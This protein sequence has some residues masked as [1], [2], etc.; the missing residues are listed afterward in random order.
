MMKNL[1]MKILSFVWKTRLCYFSKNH[2]CG[3]VGWPIIFCDFGRFVVVILRK[4]KLFDSAGDETPTFKEIRAPSWRYSVTKWLSPK[5]PN[6]ANRVS[7]NFPWPDS[8]S[9]GAKSS[10]YS[11]HTFWA[12]QNP[13]N[14]IW[15]FF[16]LGGWGWPG[17]GEGAKSG[18][19]SSVLP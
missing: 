7:D 1:K 16:L 14:S 2:L 17:K 3:W 10:V 5:S 19:A 8:A 12:Y 6:R 4:N 11:S 13:Q 18:G 15:G 9:R